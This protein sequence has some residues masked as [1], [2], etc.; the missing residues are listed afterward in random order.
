MSDTRSNLPSLAERISPEIVDALIEANT[1]PLKER[2]DALIAMCRRFLLAHQAGITNDYQDG[3][4]AAC[5]AQVQRFTA[6]NSGQVD[7]ARVVMKAPILAA[8]RKIDGSPGKPGPYARLVD[9][10][11]DAA[12]P[13]IRLVTAYKVKK[14]EEIR[15]AAAA[16]AERK[17]L[18]AEAVERAASKGSSM[19]TY[20]DA[21]AAYELAD[22]AQAIA[23]AK[24]ADLTRAKGD[25]F[26]TTSLRYKR[27]VTIVEPDKVPRQYCVPDLALIQRAAGKAGAPIPTIAGCKI[28]DVPDLTV[29]R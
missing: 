25:D 11:E 28:E 16:E 23:D 5:L 20:E 27:V 26:G 6:K 14:E 19:V 3:L 21:A 29:R 4:A 12:A 18:E 7:T 22:Q 2:A 24:P 13:V 17:R 10:V 9:V 15:K 8:Q 1:R